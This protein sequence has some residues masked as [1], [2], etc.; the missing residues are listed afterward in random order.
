MLVGVVT[1]PQVSGNP[2]VSDRGSLTDFGQG[3]AFLDQVFFV[4][5]EVLHDFI[6]AHFSEKVKGGKPSFKVRETALFPKDLTL[7]LGGDAL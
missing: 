7:Q 4:A 3:V 6:M 5:V 1:I 2:L